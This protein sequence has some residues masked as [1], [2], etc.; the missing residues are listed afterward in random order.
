MMPD[1]TPPPVSIGIE[2]IIEHAE[3]LRRQQIK[4]ETNCAHCQAVLATLR[5]VP[6]LERVADAARKLD[7]WDLGAPP[8]C[9]KCGARRENS[10]CAAFIKDADEMSDAVEALAALAA[11]K[12]P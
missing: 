5:R 2:K 11:T 12:E 3:S 8:V 6:A 10:P 1:P 9:K 7:S 4:L